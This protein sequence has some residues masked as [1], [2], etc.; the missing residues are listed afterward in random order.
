MRRKYE[1]KGDFLPTEENYRE[2]N[3]TWRFLYRIIQYIA[4]IVF[5]LFVLLLIVKRNYDIAFKYGIFIFVLMVLNIYLDHSVHNFKRYKKR[6]NNNLQLIENR[7]YDDNILFTVGDTKQEWDYSKINTIIEGDNL[8][9]LV[10]SAYKGIII[11]KNTMKAKDIEP[12]KK[13]LLSKCSVRSIDRVPKWIHVLKSV[14]WICS[15][16]TF[17]VTLVLFITK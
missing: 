8:I 1:F 17:C 15:L 6:V 12:F 4:I 14:S 2:L 16:I 10:T 3:Q 9:I 13:F 7:F 11:D 5:C